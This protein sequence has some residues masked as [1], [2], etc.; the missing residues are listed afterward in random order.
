[1]TNFLLLTLGFYLWHIIGVTVGLHRLLSHR[2]FSCP[3][4]VEYFFIV[5]AYLAFHGSP[6]WWA[7]IHRAHHKHVDTPL[8]PHAPNNGMKA[9]MDFWM[10]GRYQDHIDPRTQSPDL[11]KDPVYRFL[12]QKSHI[13][14]D[15]H[16]TL[17]LMFCILF[18]VMLWKCF[19]WEVALASTIAGIIAL[20]VPI[21]LNVVCHLPK[22]GYRNLPTA[23]DSVN[24]WW[25]GVICVGEGWHN[26]HHAS[27]GSS[28]QGWRWFEFDL[29]WLIIR[30]LSL[31]GLSWDLH[32]AG[33]NHDDDVVAPR[34]LVAL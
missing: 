17:N 23:D 26:N 22:L 24:V 3:K 14:W 1:M 9:A 27:P 4:F 34:D 19:G 28:K 2:S 21:W 7:T 5:P 11:L 16:Y 15:Q 30:A 6:V 13:H 20:N 10:R 31:V 18:R 32:R 33:L 29:S 12:D 8:D 25:M